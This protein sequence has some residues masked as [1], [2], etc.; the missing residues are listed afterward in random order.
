MGCHVRETWHRP[1]AAAP[2]EPPAWE[3]SY[4]ADAA[5]KGKKKK[6]RKEKKAVYKPLLIIGISSD[7]SHESFESVLHL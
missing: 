5:L 7:T 3:P 6:K 4:A 2:I 1:A